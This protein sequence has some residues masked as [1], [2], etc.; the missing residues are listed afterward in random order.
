MIKATVPLIGSQE[1][2]FI[3]SIY[4][5]WIIENAFYIQTPVYILYLQKKKKKKCKDVAN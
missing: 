4:R 3:V 2:I 5:L 1:A